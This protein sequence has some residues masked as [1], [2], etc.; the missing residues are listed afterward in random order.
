MEFDDVRKEYQLNE[1]SRRNLDLDPFRQFRKWFSD[2]L[3]AKINEP[4]AMCLATAS[5]E[6]IPS[7]RMVL[8]KHFDETGFHFFTNYESRKARE[9]AE[10]PH[11]S[12]TIYWKELE[13]QILAEGKVQK[14]SEKES[15]AY[16]SKRPRGSQLGTWAS[17]QDA[18][19]SS[20]QFLEEEYQ[21]YE[22]LYKNQEIPLP[23]YWGGFRLIPKRFEFW[24]GRMSRL[25]DRFR[26]VLEGDSWQLDR[27]SP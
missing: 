14:V 22:N 1:L 21:R 5:A 27:L 3:E 19:I 4:N 18:V 17:R 16:F 26:Y 20:R 24:Q 10:N 23:P 11:A 13:R 7:S 2:A 12:I 9:L 6:G 8:L 15:K 25:S